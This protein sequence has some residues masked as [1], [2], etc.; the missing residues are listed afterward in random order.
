MALTAH[1][2]RKKQSGIALVE[3]LVAGLLFIVGVLGLLGALGQTMTIEADSEFR[4]QAA[5]LAS[6]MMN[7]IWLGVNR[8]GGDVGVQVSL[9]GF[10]HQPTTVGYCNFSGSASANADVAGWIQTMTDGQLNDIT[11]RL[12]GASSS[13]QQILV[14]TATNNQVTITL[15]WQ[16][17]KDASPRKYVLRSYVN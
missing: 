3:A 12:P 11:A 14:D 5:K 8:A 6:K 10:V 13:M 4:N 1:K 2:N 9:A 15:C 7:T 16:S 17:S